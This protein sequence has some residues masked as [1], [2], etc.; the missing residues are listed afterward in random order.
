MANQIAANFR[1]HPDDQ[2]AGEIADHLRSFWTPWMLG[3]L[4]Q[5]VDG[6]GEGLDPLVVAAAGLLASPAS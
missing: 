6:G 4:L 1:H 3:R 5:V 2:A